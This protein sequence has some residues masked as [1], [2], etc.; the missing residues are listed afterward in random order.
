MK[1]LALF[2]YILSSPQEDNPNLQWLVGKTGGV[3]NNF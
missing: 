1:T 2:V 3:E